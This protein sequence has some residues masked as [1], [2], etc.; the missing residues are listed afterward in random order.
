MTVNCK[1]SCHSNRCASTAVAGT[2]MH[3]IKILDTVLLAV[4]LF[5]VSLVLR[6]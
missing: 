2:S 1:M 3:I 5:V 6:N 4:S